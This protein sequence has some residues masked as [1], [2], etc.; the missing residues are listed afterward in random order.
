MDL[1]LLASRQ[2]VFSLRHLVLVVW[3]DRYRHQPGVRHHHQLRYRFPFFPSFTHIMVTL[4]QGF[5][6]FCF[7]AHIMVTLLRVLS[8][9]HIRVSLL[10]VL[11]LR[12]LIISCVI[13]PFFLLSLS[14]S[15]SFAHMIVTLLQ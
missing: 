7:L 14:L 6:L 3:N 8:F 15:L 5:V 11:S 13:G 2:A 1:L 12:S 9:L 10:Q 4:L